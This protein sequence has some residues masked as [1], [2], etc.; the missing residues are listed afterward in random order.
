MAQMSPYP[1]RIDKDSL[2][3]IKL[4][5]AKTGFSV[6]QIMRA[7][8]DAGLPLVIERNLKPAPLLSQARPCAR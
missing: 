6:P 5:A 1:L 4:G 2:K 3:A 7:A 8:M